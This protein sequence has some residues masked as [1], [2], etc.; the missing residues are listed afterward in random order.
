MVHAIISLAKSLG[1][2]VTGEGIETAEHDAL[3][4]HRGCDLGQGCFY[5]RPSDPESVA[6]LVVATAAEPSLMVP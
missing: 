3:L 1:R 2:S 4:T 6:T 5:G